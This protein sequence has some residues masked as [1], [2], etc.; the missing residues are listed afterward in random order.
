M[1]ENIWLSIPLAVILPVIVFTASCTKKVVQTHPVSITEPEVQKEP[2]RSAEEASARE[3]AV[4]AFVKENIPFAFNSSVLSDQAQQILNGKAD[5][6][7]KNPDITITVEGYCDDRGTD[8]Y[9]IAL[10]ERRAK[11][12]KNFL[13]DLGIRTNRLNT[14]TYGEERPISMGHNE[15]SWA[16]NRRAQFVIN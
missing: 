6:L 5:Y 1:R 3:A 15:A 9:N 7:R 11:S 14:L 10:G 8:A 16:K 2:D 13:I 12:V 4:T